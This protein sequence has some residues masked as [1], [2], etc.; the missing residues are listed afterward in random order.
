MNALK[1]CNIAYFACYA[2]VD[3]IK[4]AKSTLLLS[5][6]V[7]EKLTLEDIDAISYG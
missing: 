7:L 2:A 4:P 3:R 6:D 5:R 1:S